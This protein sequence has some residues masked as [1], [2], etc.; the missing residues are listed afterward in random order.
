MN[1]VFFAFIPLFVASIAI[2]QSNG[3]T[4]QS[5]EAPTTQPTKLTP[6]PTTQEMMQDKASRLAYGAELYRLVNQKDEVVAVLRNG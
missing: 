1:R 3:P 6:L 5:A 2:A 4:S